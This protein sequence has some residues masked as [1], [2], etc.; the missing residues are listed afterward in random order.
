MLLLWWCT[1]RIHIES[2]SIRG[3]SNAR[4]LVGSLYLMVS[5]GIWIITRV[6]GKG[7]KYGVKFWY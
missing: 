2:G 6:F 7:P 3:S 5:A 1:Q 4:G